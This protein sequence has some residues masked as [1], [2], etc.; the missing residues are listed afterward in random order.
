MLEAVC[1]WCALGNDL[2]NLC[3][4]KVNLQGI[5][6]MDIL[7][8]LIE[9]YSP[10]VTS[11]CCDLEKDIEEALR[12]QGLVFQ[13]AFCGYR[14]TKPSMSDSRLDEPRLRE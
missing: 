3:E 7:P 11:V 12:E 9:A 6:K 4:R 14:V 1:F 13:Y 5:W 10:P 2:L 8:F